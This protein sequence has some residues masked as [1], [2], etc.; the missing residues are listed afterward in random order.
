MYLNFFILFY[1]SIETLYIQIDLDLLFVWNSKKVRDAEIYSVQS[2]EV[3]VVIASD[4]LM[5]DLFEDQRPRCITNAGISHIKTLTTLSIFQEF[6]AHSSA[7]CLQ[8]AYS[9]VKMIK[10]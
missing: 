4:W 2:V 9:L 5:I 10:I 3:H 7:S 8:C 6:K 1:K